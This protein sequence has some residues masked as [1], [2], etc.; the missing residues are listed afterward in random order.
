M[1]V[2]LEEMRGEGEERSGETYE[3]GPEMDCF[4]EFG[5]DILEFWTGEID[6]VWF[7]EGEVSDGVEVDEGG[8][9]E[10]GVWKEGVGVED[11]I[12][13]EV[14]GGEGEPGGEEELCGLGPYGGEDDVVDEGRETG[15]GTEGVCEETEELVGGAEADGVVEEG[16]TDAV[17]GAADEEERGT[18]R[19]VAV[20]EDRLEQLL[21]TGRQTR[22]DH[23]DL[24][25]TGYLY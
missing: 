3:I 6:V 22:H 11:G 8:A 16:G 25:V 2:F 13:G 17:E 9:E 15:V 24:S 21:G 12:E 18:G 20:A 7:A 19:G 10:L 5:E 14:E 4:G 1:D 23:P